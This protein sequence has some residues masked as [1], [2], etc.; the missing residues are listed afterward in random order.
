MKLAKL[1][2]DIS[3]R[4]CVV[5]PVSLDKK[6]KGAI[7]LTSEQIKFMVG[8]QTMRYV[9]SYPKEK[10]ARMEFSKYG[11]RPFVQNLH[12][13]RSNFT[14]KYKARIRKKETRGV[15]STIYSNTFLKLD[16]NS[17]GRYTNQ[18]L[19][20]HKPNLFVQRKLAKRKAK[21]S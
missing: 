19:R 5:I 1:I 18:S 2:A 14:D 15:Q 4:K 3:G 21:N 7:V 16:I 17:S 13:S 6:M 10:N 11:A 8:L 12:V 20:K 9:Q